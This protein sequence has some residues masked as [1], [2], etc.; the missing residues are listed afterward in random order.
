MIT[1]DQSEASIQVTWTLLTNQR[2]ANR[3]NLTR[4]DGPLSDHLRK[5]LLGMEC[6]LDSSK[7]EY[8][9]ADLTDGVVMTDVDD[10]WLMM[11]LTTMIVRRWGLILPIYWQNI[12][13][14]RC[15]A[16]DEDWTRHPSALD[17]S[18]GRQ[19]EIITP[20]CLS[21]ARDLQTS[22]YLY[23]SNYLLIFWDQR[24]MNKIFD[25][26]YLWFAA[27]SYCQAQG[28][29]Q[30]L[31]NVRSISYFRSISYKISSYL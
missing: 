26:W 6:S 24:K 9:P 11:I 29:S 17:C 10:L 18:G 20:N 13:P 22:L 2:R 27:G 31:V 3:N 23:L 4:H 12:N 19:S 25:K 5:Y 7:G 15:Q 30:F 14:W 28:P 21:L 1:L 8:S 16:D